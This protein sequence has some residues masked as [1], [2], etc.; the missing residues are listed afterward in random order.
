MLH[1]FLV[2]MLPLAH[3]TATYCYD[4]TQKTTASRGI[5]GMGPARI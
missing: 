1:D 4:N 3:E 5:L 2:K